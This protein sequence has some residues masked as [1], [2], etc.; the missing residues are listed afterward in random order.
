MSKA[1]V[2]RCDEC[3]TWDSVGMHVRTVSVCGPRFDLCA[4]CRI[5]KLLAAGVTLE[6]AIAYVTVFDQR[7]VKP[8]THLTMAAALKAFQAQQETETPVQPDV[9]TEDGEPEELDE[10]AAARDAHSVILKAA[11]AALA[12]PGSAVDGAESDHSEAEGVATPESEGETEKRPA[13]GRR[14][15]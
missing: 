15:K 10:L 11:D 1:T 7:G 4:K 12:E 9:E 6:Q 8:G 2:L 3:E 5:K 14:A 13:R